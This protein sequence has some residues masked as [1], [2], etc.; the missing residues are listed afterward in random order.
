MVL[1]LLGKKSWNVYNTQAIEQ[2]K[3]DE[4]A[5][6]R[7]EQEEEE[8]L[9]AQDAAI[10]IAR[11]RGE[12]PPTFPSPP[13]RAPEHGPRRSEHSRDTGDGR[14]REKKRK[15]VH[16]E[17][18][19]D[20]EMR[21]AREDVEGEGE[22]QRSRLI[23]GERDRNAPIHDADGHFQ[24]FVEPDERERRKRE[25]EDSHKR[26]KKDDA[27]KQMQNMRFKDATGYSKSD[28]SSGNPWYT[29]STTAPAQPKS[30]D[31]VQEKD[32]WGNEDTGRKER[33]QVRLSSSDPL[34]MMNAGA[35]AV[36][37][38]EAEKAAY[39]K[40]QKAELDQ[41]KQDQECERR[42]ER[43]DK[44]RD[45]G[46]RGHRRREDGDG[47]LDSRE[48]MTTKN[49]QTWTGLT[50]ATDM[51]IVAITTVILVGTR[52]VAK[53][54]VAAH[55]AAHLR[56]AESGTTAAGAVALDIIL[57]ALGARCAGPPRRG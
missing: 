7:R 27:E 4:A 32:V 33:A 18:E 53:L 29:S 49:M 40:Q 45:D 41:L 57:A 10:R 47:K 54:E 3:R 12:T 25:A 2:V 44:K 24:L 46:E 13:S 43:G 8:R 22:A 55:V 26:R 56:V 21:Y 36:R 15:R 42:R 38:H 39:R 30:L 16:G 5:A 20:R 14:S 19:K 35:A 11:L 51:M 34:A 31:T 23:V 37:K 17:D 48:R 50:T 9:E 1:H 28:S 6:K 52:R